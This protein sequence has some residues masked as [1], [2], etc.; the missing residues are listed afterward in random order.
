MV[1]AVSQG[2][3]VIRASAAKL[4]S[5]VRL[6]VTACRGVT[7]RPVFEASKAARVIPVISLSVRWD[8]AVSAVC[9]ESAGSAVN[10]VSRVSKVWRV[11]LGVKVRS[12]RKVSAV[13]RL[14]VRAGSKVS[15]VPMGFLANYQL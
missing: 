11:C 1:R 12:D 7:V 13:N 15:V 2:Q 8:R 9:P 6:V 14:L 5:L 3:R 4:D 10:E